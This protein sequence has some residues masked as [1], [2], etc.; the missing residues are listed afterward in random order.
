MRNSADRILTTQAGS[1]PRPDDLIALHR[2][3]GEGASVDEAAFRARLAAATGEV[4]AQQRKVGLDVPGDGEYRKSMGHSVDYG[5]WWTHSFQRLSGLEL[6]DTSGSDSPGG[7]SP[8]PA[9]TNR[10]DWVA[11][12]DAYAD[13]DSGITLGPP[14]VHRGELG[15]HQPRPPLRST[16]ASPRCGSRRSI[17]RCAGSRPTGF[18]FTCAGEAG[19]DR[20]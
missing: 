4:V 15:S 12:A 11:F 6:V 8:N 7:G 3:R 14:P 2:A 1:L 20:T 17:T 9:I 13:P 5:A 19:T 10:R 16:G 18:G